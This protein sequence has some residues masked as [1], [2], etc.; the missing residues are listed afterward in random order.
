M[1]ILARQVLAWGRKRFR[2][3]MDQAN[4]GIGKKCKSYEEIAHL[5]CNVRSAVQV[6]SGITLLAMTDK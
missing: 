6:L 1:S 3:R 5:H 4:F 2:A